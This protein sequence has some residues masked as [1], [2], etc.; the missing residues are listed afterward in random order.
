LDGLDVYREQSPSGTSFRLRAPQLNMFAIVSENLVNGRREVFSNIHIAEPRAD[1]FE[2][3]RGVAV[4]QSDVVSGIVAVQPDDP[5][6]L[7]APWRR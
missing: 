6:V 1:L 7:T 4:T 3:P 2:P 5:R